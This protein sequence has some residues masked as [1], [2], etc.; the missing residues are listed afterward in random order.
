MKRMLPKNK[1]VR[2]IKIII[3][4]LIIP[5]LLFLIVSG[6]GPLTPQNQPKDFFI[7]HNM[8]DLDQVVSISKFR[9]CQGHRSMSQ[10]TTEPDSSMA[11]YIL[12][13]AK[14]YEGRTTFS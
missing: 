8:F 12:T 7:T 13:N 9:S 3:I 10:G 6:V 2:L 11:H 14:E 5:F 1:L 4:I